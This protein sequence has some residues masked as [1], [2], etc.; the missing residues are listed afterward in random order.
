MNSVRAMVIGG[1]SSELLQEEVHALTKEER[2]KLLNDGGFSLEI[3]VEKGLAMK[4]ALA[5][6]WNKLRRYDL[7]K[8]IAHTCSY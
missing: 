3:P 2:Q 4:V 6:P 8:S 7:Y 1:T 5:I